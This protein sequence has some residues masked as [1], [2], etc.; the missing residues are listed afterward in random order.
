M[1]HSDVEF[2]VLTAGKP[3]ESWVSKNSLADEGEFAILDSFLRNQS[4]PP[5]FWI[6]LFNDVPVDTDALSSLTGEPGGATGY[7]AQQVLRS[8]NADGWPTLALDGGDWM[9]TSKQVTFRFR[10]A[11]TIQYS[12]LATS[13]D[14]SGRLICYA[15]LSSQ[16]VMASGEDLRVTIKPKLS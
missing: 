10:A 2:V 13:S 14:N 5:S 4:H 3:V 1:W 11:A 8:A 7:A 16:R 15:P 6:R 9:A 12:V